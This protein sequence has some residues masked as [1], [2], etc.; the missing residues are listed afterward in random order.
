MTP[1][2]PRPRV[3]LTLPDRPW[4]AD[5][6]KRMRQ[7]AT[8]RAL[9]ALD[10]DLDVV[11]LFAGAP[12]A[13][14]LPPG[15]TVRSCRQVDFPPTNKVVALAAVLLHALPW[16]IAV[17]PWRR[18]RRELRPLLDREYDLVWF[19]A[20]DHAL[21]LARHVRAAHTVVDMDDIEV[22]KLKAFLRLPHDQDDN[23]GLVRIQRR[24]ELP[25]WR[26]AVRRVKRHPDVVVVCSDLDRTRLGDGAT[27]AVV[28][29]GYPDPSERA[30]S[31][32][33][34]P[35]SVLFIGTY[36]YPPNVDAAVFA[37]TEVLPRLR[38]HLPDAR[39]R[40]VGRGGSELLAHLAQLPGVELVGAVDDPADELARNHVSLAPIR[41]GGGTR[42]KIL[43]A[44]A[45]RLPVV[46]TS[47]A[48]E[49]L[50]VVADKHVLVADDAEGLARACARIIGDDDL[51]DR[52]RRAGHD[53]YADRYRTSVARRAVQDIVERLLPN[54]GHS[55]ER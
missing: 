17:L 4:P 37:A 42:I 8:L 12:I 43:E 52:L 47:L 10:V 30:Y 49:G 6:G 7:S 14:P 5:G 45:H 31:S 46:T 26:W 53:L 41:Y 13:D 24:I 36:Y 39:L 40:L 44:F 27:V 21:R 51:A 55:V 19:S 15:V 32:A 1:P 16:Q 29:N 20:S 50:D 22:P 35:P 54:S 28:P 2:V 23:R 38:R 48:C 33:M 11:V 25:L 9:A 18:V 3:L 34:P